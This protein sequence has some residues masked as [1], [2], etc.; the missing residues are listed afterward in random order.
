MSPHRRRLTG[1]GI[2]HA[3]DRATAP[4]RVPQQ[5]RMPRAR[6]FPHEASDEVIETMM[7]RLAPCRRWSAAV[8]DTV[9]RSLAPR[10]HR[11]TCLQA[12]AVPR[13]AARRAPAAPGRAGFRCHA[14]RQGT[15]D[16]CAM[17]QEA[18]NRRDAVRRPPP[19]PC[20]A[21]QVGCTILSRQGHSGAAAWLPIARPLERTGCA[22]DM[23]DRSEDPRMQPASSDPV[24]RA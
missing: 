22:T 19:H 23:G 4:H 6:T 13:S 7:A 17:V 15:P 2:G 20:V 10:I 18:S 5:P 8:G 14:T 21:A 3:S 12:T 1:S 16:L 9:Q 11:A 24:C